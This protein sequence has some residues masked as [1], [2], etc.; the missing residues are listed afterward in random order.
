MA[1][2]CAGKLILPG[3]LSYEPHLTTVSDANEGGSR[4]ELPSDDETSG[5]YFPSHRMCTIRVSIVRLEHSQAERDN[6]FL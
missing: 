2:T 4:R 3:L 6:S 1:T 5:R